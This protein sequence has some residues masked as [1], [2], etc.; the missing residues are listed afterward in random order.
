[1]KKLILTLGILISSVIGMSQTVVYDIYKTV[2]CDYNRYTRDYEYSR[3]LSHDGMT[4]TRYKDVFVV[5]DAIHSTYRIN[6]QIGSERSD[7]VNF[8]GSDEKLVTVGI[9][10][11]VTDGELTITVLYPDQFSV[12]Y[13]VR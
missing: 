13:F 5:S 10:F 4:I 3:T 11:C 7:C 9:S 2:S 1:M 8:I 12:T 6:S